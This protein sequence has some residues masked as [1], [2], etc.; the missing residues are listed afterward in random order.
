MLQFGFL[1]GLKPGNA[2]QQTFSYDLSRHALPGGKLRLASGQ[3]FKPAGG[4][5][6][7]IGVV[8]H[9]IENM[10]FPFGVPVPSVYSEAGPT[11]R[12]SD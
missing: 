3:R 5:M 4:D 12:G 7:F 6:G 9:E 8:K 10:R 11:G 1:L 2:V